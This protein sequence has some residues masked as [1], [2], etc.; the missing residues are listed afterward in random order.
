MWFCLIFIWPLGMWLLYRKRDQYPQW[1][2]IA[3]ITLIICL[4]LNIY[5]NVLDKKTEPTAPQKVEQASP[6]ANSET[7]KAKTK[8]ESDGLNIT[9]TDYWDL[10]EQ[11][12]AN[13][14]HTRVVGM[15]MTDYWEMEHDNGTADVKGT[16][17][18]EN[19]KHTFRARFGVKNKQLL[20]L[21]IDDQTI[22]FA[23]DA[24]DKIMDETTA[25]NKQQ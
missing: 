13:A 1:K 17:N 2:K 12:V 9:K 19:K 7:N 15:N 14:L 18:F 20:L 24:Q 11:A 25:A 3:G 4:G 16:F 22:L 6:K 10:S 5:P 21:K 8:Q 23:E